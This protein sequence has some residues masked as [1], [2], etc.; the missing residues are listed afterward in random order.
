MLIN[1]IFFY[2]YKT[3]YGTSLKVEFRIY[4]LNNYTRFLMA[5]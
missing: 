5:A 1:K 3:F 2:Y 4:K